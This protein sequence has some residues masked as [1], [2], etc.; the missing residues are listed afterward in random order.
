M[1]IK[2][3]YFKLAYA[4]L[5]L[6][7][8][9]GLMAAL[10]A[11]YINPHSL[12][13]PAFLGLAFPIIWL[14][15]AG[16]LLFSFFGDRRIFIITMI[17]LLA[18]T[19]MMFRHVN[20]S[21][22]RGCTED[23]GLF[24]IMSYNVQG[25]DGVKGNN[26]YETQNT[27]HALINKHS[28][29]IVCFQDYA[30]KGMK[31]AQFYKNLNETL[32]QNFLQ[33]SDYKASELST[34][35]ILVTA[36]KHI[37]VDQGSIYS[38]GNE[39]FAIYSDIELMSD[40]IRVFNV[41]LQSVKLIDEKALLK[42]DRKQILKRNIFSEVFSTIE[43]LRNAFYIR[44][45]Q[46]L[47]LAEAIKQSPHPVIVAGDFNDTPA[48][49]AYKTISKTLHDASFLR[50]NGIKPTY[51]ESDYPLI[52]DYILAGK[53]LKTCNYKRLRIIFSDHYPIVTNFSF[54]DKPKK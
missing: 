49:F 38:P 37:I 53:H 46:A 2:K 25:F 22:K 15:N 4:A 17:Y 52:I 23:T 16:N 40:T 48:S 18:G 30:M 14:L 36:S 32:Q 44:S 24:K 21:V 42:P 10:L 7:L 43:K 19:P 51:V 45:S 6:M 34:Q 29:D 27:I 9:A 28:P 12:M 26:K 41:H 39:I 33:F 3:K 8:L 50:A 47:M 20:L 13:I 54:K 1:R 35:Y 5:T 31:H 11:P